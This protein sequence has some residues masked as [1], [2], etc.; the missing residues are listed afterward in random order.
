MRAKSF[1]VVAFAVFSAL[2]AAAAVMTATFTGTVSQPSGPLNGNAF[3]AKFRYDTAIGNLTQLNG[4]QIVAG[5]TA[6]NVPSPMLSM[7]MRIAGAPQF[8]VT[9]EN[10]DD[11][12]SVG[13]F[14]SDFNQY[15]GSVGF[16]SLNGSHDLRDTSGYLEFAIIDFSG[17]APTGLT[18]DTPFAGA[19]SASGNNNF[20]FGLQSNFVVVRSLSVGLLPTYVSVESA[21]AVP[22]PGIWAM[23]IVGFG[24]TGSV[25][26]RRASANCV[27]RV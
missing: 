20:S 23:M 10:P 2:P 25:M 9:V 12:A 16:M 3:T 27:A 4:V 22:E 17:F 6:L 15:F 18:L 26:R 11:Y 5:G 24:L 14:A 1:A 7:S 8:N 13:N 21:S 19:F